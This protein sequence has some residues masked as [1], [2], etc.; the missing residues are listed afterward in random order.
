MLVRALLALV[1]GCVAIV[2]ACSDDDTG[3][4][5]APE[6]QEQQ[7][8]REQ[9]AA[10]EVE[11]EPEGSTER[12]DAA[13][14]A[15]AETA[16]ETQSNETPARTESADS[17]PSEPSETESVDTAASESAAGDPPA[18]TSEQSA[19]EETSGPQSEPEASASQARSQSAA[20][21]PPAE[22]SE[23]SA[24]EE[25]SDAQT[26]PEGTGSQARSQSAA[27]DPPA[28]TSEQ[29]ATEEPSGAQAEP[30]TSVSQAQPQQ[31]VAQPEVQSEPEPELDAPAAADNA[32]EEAEESHVAQPPATDPETDTEEEQTAR[33]APPPVGS[34]DNVGGSGAM[35]EEEPVGREPLDATPLEGSGQT[36]GVPISSANTYTWQDGKYTRTITHQSDLTVTA[37]AE[38]GSEIGPRQAGGAQSDSQPVF[39]SDTGETMT[40]PGGVLLVLD[41]EWDQARIDRFFTDNHM[42]RSLVQERTF[43]TN[44]Y[45]IETEPGF[46]SL[47]LA[48]ELAGQDGVLL[49]SPNW[50][51]EVELQ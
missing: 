5:M 40:L 20:G 15:A 17:E 33:V 23:Q 2:I 25:P 22:T 11:Q 24:T 1:V 8:Q 19:S 27:G 16:Q 3:T 6:L 18:E 26:E 21:D 50:Q 7:E 14:T 48:N 43:T 44:A 4:D 32:Q 37:R 29:S 13:P 38:G 35:T 12:R 34:D 42:D 49:S 39:Q 51:T 45:F 47:N 41:A 31:A 9:Q 46:P 36:D 28:E 10:V 30:E